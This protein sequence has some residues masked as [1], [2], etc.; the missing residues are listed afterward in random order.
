ML[1]ESVASALWLTLAVWTLL[2]ASALLR[3]ALGDAAA[4]VGIAGACLL[5]LGGD[6]HPQRLRPALAPMLLAGVAGFA[7]LPGWLVLLAPIGSALGLPPRAALAAAPG[8]LRML[9]DV[10]LGPLLEEALYRARLLPALRTALGAP[11]A[12]LLSSALF[13]LP[14][15]DPWL[16]LAAFGVGLALGAAFLATRSLALCVAYHA[17][18]NL[19]AAAWLRGL[20]PPLSPAAASLLAW[21][22]FGAAIVRA[23]A[24]RAGA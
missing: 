8:P 10:G 1:R 7:S 3:P 17:G 18:L 6:P 24:A 4:L 12:L 20:F 23:R 16:V 13:A 5:L 2:A 19:A 11:L 21:L 14:H 22:L 9:C 15:G